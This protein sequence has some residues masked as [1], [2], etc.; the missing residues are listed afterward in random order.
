MDSNNRSNYDDFFKNN[1]SGTNASNNEKN[2]HSSSEAP[3]NSYNP[4]APTNHYSNDYNNGSR[5]Q[6]AE[7]RVVNESEAG[8]S[9]PK[10]DQNTM[11]YYSYGQTRQPDA[12][13]TTNH[14]YNQQQPPYAQHT[15][16]SSGHP[17]GNNS[18]QPPFR[19]FTTSQGGGS[20]PF[21]PK[22]EKKRSSGFGKMFLSFL[23]GVMV[24]GVLM[25][26]AD[27]QNWFTKESVVQTNTNNQN[28]SNTEAGSTASSSLLG[29]RPDNIADLFKTASPAVV[30][31]ETYTKGAASSGSSLLDDPFFRQF[32]GDS[33]PN[34]NGGGSTGGEL[35]QSG[36]GTGFFFEDSGYILTNQHVIADADEI[37]VVVEGYDEPFVAKQLGSSFDLDLAVIKVEG[38]KPFP[39]LPL[40]SSDNIQI[41]D[42]VVA[43][44]NPYGFDHTLTIG[45]LS[46]KERP[47]NIADTNDTRNYENLLQ[48]D[49]S[50]NPG[51]SGGPLLNV[52]GEVI[53][54]NTA[55]S[56]TAQGIGFAIP[57]ST[58]TEV[59]EQLKNNEPLPADQS[60]FI[61]AELQNISEEIAA[62]A[63]LSSTDGTI[64]RSVYYNSPAYQGGVK[65]YDVI[66]GV[67]DQAIKTTNELVSYIQSKEVGTEITLKVIRDGQ[68]IELPVTVGD[69]NAFGLQ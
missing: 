64:V 23:A 58:I 19:P 16:G 35:Q 25:Y 53:G 44:G 49:A 68:N 61:G 8:S 2:Q 20:D 33:V 54:I 46:A 30:K 15:T 38:E 40:G 4:S 5:V 32:F 24:V 62:Q 55:V 22:K 65:Q 59:L 29:E 36:M 12:V 26:T 21:T 39:T 45:V 48:T 18:M 69:K 9:E 14:S 37:R 56:S 42:W 60:P 6:D 67:D 1:N 51:N 43:I 66:T 3:S 57:T 10:P 7:Y 50:I 52:N 28:Q 27:A 11:Y 17:E 41:G 63:G 47:I 13:A 31:I 34:N